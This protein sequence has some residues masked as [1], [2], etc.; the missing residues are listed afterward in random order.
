MKRRFTVTKPFCSNVIIGCGLLDVCIV[1]GNVDQ[2]LGV[3]HYHGITPH[4]VPS[5]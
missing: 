5:P 2:P 4:I 1:I 3:E